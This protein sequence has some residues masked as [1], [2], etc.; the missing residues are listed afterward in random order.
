MLGQIS[1]TSKGVYRINLNAAG[2]A[3]VQAWIDNPSNNFGIIIKD[4]AVSSGVT[5]S[6]SEAKTA[7]QRPKLIINYKPNQPPVVDVGPTLSVPAGQPLVIGAT[8]TDDGQP[9]AASLLMALWTHVSGP[10]TASFDDD[11]A[12]S[13]TV[14]FSDPGTYVLRLTVSDTLLSGFDELTVSVV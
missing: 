3:A 2:V 11:H 13:T 1:A 10:G 4:Y 5:I 9:V 12:V 6:S 7:S 8:V 14:T